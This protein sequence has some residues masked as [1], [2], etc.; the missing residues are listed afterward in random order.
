MTPLFDTWYKHHCSIWFLHVQFPP[1]QIKTTLPKVAQNFKIWRAQALPFTKNDKLPHLGRNANGI[2]GILYTH[3]WCSLL[4]RSRSRLYF[5]SCFHFT[6][7]L[8]LAADFSVWICLDVLIW[9]DLLRSRL[10]LGTQ[11][12]KI[13]GNAGKEFITWMIIQILEPTVIVGHNKIVWKRI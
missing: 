4:S 8:R 9:V 5:R 13:C 2:Q 6:G 1:D 12:G 7:S 10:M 11:L 3:A